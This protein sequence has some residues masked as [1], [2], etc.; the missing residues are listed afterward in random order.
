MSAENVT[1]VRPSW[2]KRHPVIFW[3]VGIIAGLFVYGIIASVVTHGGAPAYESAATTSEST[4]AA[5][6]GLGD[7]VRDGQFAFVVHSVKCGVLSVGSQY[8]GATAQGQFCLVNLTVKNIGDSSQTMFSSNQLAYKGAT[9]YSADDA[10][11]I[12]AAKN[13]D[14]PWLKDINPGNSL[15]GTIVFD[16]PKGV[17]PDKLELH[18]SAFSGGAQV[19]T[20]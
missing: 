18:D 17:T 13:G 8:L 9:K 15:K 14:S 7:E 1:T 4:K 10:A 3:S 16:V 12:Y 20:S 11:T 5:N 2:R 6:P 19:A